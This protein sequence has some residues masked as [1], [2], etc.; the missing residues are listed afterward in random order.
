[1]QKQDLGLIENWLRSIRDVYRLHASE[2]DSIEDEKKRTR[3]LVELNVQEQVLNIFKTA[4]V[5]KRRKVR[6]MI[7]SSSPLILN[8]VNE[9]VTY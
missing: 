6:V 1:M 8:F 3:R 4:S 5:Q 9:L 7:K 2:L